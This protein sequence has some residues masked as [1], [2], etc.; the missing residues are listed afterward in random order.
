MFLLLLVCS[1]VLD[2]DDDEE[3]EGGGGEKEEDVN[4]IKAFL[5]Y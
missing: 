2:Y 1:G 3:E 5:K 4:V